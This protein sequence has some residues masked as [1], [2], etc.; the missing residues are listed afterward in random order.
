M[1][2]PWC[3]QRCVRVCMR[4]VH[5]CKHCSTAHQTRCGSLYATQCRAP[6]SPKTECHT[7]VTDRL[8]PSAGGGKSL[9]YQLPE[10]IMERLTVV[11]SPLISLIQDQIFHLEE[12]GVSARGLT[13]PQDYM[14]QNGIMHECASPHCACSQ[15][16]P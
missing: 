14:E 9:C 8:P 5:T 12:A 3:L 1:R 11:V 10:V 13:G 2:G 15:A 4:C 7:D 16:N 6:Q